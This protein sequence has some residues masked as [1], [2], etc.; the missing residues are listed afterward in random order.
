MK[1]VIE[2]IPHLEQRYPTVGDWQ[3][4]GPGELRIAVS[5][6]SD[7]RREWLVAVHEL[8]EALLCIDAGVTQDEVDR[9][10]LALL[11]NDPEP[12]DNP[13]SPYRRQHCLASAVERLL[14]AEFGVSW[15]AYEEELAAL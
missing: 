7:P 2:T 15:R 10:D 3:I 5:R 12:G 6:M 14:A 8:I 11:Y 13:D 9:F 4:V 1:I